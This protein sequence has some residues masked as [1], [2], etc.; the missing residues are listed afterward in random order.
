M[1]E[2]CPGLFTKVMYSF[3]THRDPTNLVPKLDTVEFVCVLQQFR[4]EC[5]G[6][7]LGLGAQLVDHV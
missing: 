5:G 2:S 6:D 4:S 7:E 1:R 3:N